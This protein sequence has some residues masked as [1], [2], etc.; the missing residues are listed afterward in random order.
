MVLSLIA[1][2]NLQTLGSSFDDKIN[3]FIAYCLLTLLL[4]NY[5]NTKKLKYALWYALTIASA[6]GILIEWLQKILTN[7]RMYDVYDMIANC[8][9]AVIAVI[10]IIVYKKLKLK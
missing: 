7:N 8:F 1:I 9:G 10:F 3:H 5:L 4:Y 6:Y 2:G